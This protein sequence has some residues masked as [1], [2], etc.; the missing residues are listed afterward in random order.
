MAHPD[1][2]RGGSEKGQREHAGRTSE[3][4]DAGMKRKSQGTPGGSD[5]ASDS[6]SGASDTKRGL[7]APDV[8]GDHDGTLPDTGLDRDSGA[9]A[10]GGH[11]AGGD[12]SRGGQKG[13]VGRR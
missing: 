8:H 2:T 11:D 10:A 6:G 7:V 9:G 3:A 5:T 4:S 12:T 13:S 1:E